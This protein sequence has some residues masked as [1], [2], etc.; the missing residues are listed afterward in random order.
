MNKVYIANITP[1]LKTDVYNY[2]YDTI[3]KYRQQKADKLKKHE[4]KALSVGVGALLRFA[5]E[6]CT[7][8]CFD[9]LIFKTEDNGKP[10]VENNPFYFSL[11][12]SGDYA[13]CVISDTPVG[14]DIEKEKPFSPKMQKRFAEN[15]LEWTKKE[16]KGKLTGKGFFDDSQNEKYIYTHKKTD[17]YIIT[18]CSTK[19]FDT[20]LEYHLP[21]PC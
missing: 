4:D 11:S 12:H 9:E 14:I 19:T 16:A 1:L 13:V 15:T 2:Y 3:G 17:G 20:F 18:V 5:I 7:P 8:F 10:F 6:D 21:F